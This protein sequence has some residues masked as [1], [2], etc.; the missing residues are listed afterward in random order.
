MANWGSMMGK[1]GI[2]FTDTM[3]GIPV[4]SQALIRSLTAS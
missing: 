4:L 2:V 3:F 1:V